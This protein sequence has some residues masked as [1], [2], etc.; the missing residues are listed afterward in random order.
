MF[1]LIR[2]GAH[3]LEQGHRAMRLVIWN[4]SLNIH[5]Q[6]IHGFD[7]VHV[8]LLRKVTARELE[9]L[10][11]QLR[12]ALL[13]RPEVMKGLGVFQLVKCSDLSVASLLSVLSLVR[14]ILVAAG[15]V[16]SVAGVVRWRKKRPEVMKGLGVFQLVKCSGLSVASLLSVLSLVR[17]ILVAAGGVVS[18]AGVVRWQIRCG[19]RI[20]RRQPDDEQ[21]ELPD[22]HAGHQFR[23]PAVTWDPRGV[24]IGK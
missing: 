1:N 19:L 7:I 16:V 4:W 5:L 23:L 14:S 17:S 13:E 20:R 18:V 22:L 6:L 9:H 15:G 8:V 3:L 11:E 21:G 24:I 2:G 12:E 10:L